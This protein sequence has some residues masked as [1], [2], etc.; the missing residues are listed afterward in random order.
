MLG[1]KDGKWW[2]CFKWI[3]WFHNFPKLRRYKVVPKT[4]ALVFWICSQFIWLLGNMGLLYKS[5][6]L[7]KKTCPDPI[8][9]LFRFDQFQTINLLLEIY[10]WTFKFNEVPMRLKTS[11][12]K[13]L[14]WWFPIQFHCLIRITPFSIF[15]QRWRACW[16]HR[17]HNEE[18][19][20]LYLIWKYH[21][22]Q[23]GV[24]FF[25]WVL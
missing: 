6:I 3:K 21:Q 7:L 17:F 13:I 14:S 24:E 5:M 25:Y 8:P 20:K 16:D 23:S 18:S 22:I 15:I 4:I 11:F 1:I 2:S 9:F 10:N 12:I 19:Y